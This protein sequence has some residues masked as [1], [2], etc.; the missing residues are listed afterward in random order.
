MKALLKLSV[1]ILALSVGCVQL[2]KN[3]L[4]YL[5]VI[6]I[7][8]QSS[9]SNLPPQ[10]SKPQQP[11]VPQ[12]SQPPPQPLPQLGPPVFIPTPGLFTSLNNITLQANPITA[13][14]Y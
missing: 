9:D 5:P 8:F 1:V 12:I 11:D 3:Q 7:L 6:R 4:H 2:E 13:S 14:I 10:V